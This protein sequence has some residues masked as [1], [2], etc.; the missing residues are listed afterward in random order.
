MEEVFL[1]LGSNEGSPRDTINAA[2]ERLCQILSSARLSPLWRSRAR[3]YRDQPDFVNAAAA[4]QCSLSPRELLRAV[5]EIE[6]EFGRDRSREIKKGPRPLDIDILLYG[7][8]IVAEP[9]LIIPHAGLRERKFALLPLTELDP[10]LTDPV[11]GRSYLSILASLPP[12]GIY[13][14]DCPDYDLLYT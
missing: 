14:L 2:F 11:S 9:D 1:G 8:Q 6:A 3:Y 12:Q 10:G 4:G 7:R 13:L 5:N